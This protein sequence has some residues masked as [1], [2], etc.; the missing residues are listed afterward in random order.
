MDKCIREHGQRFETDWTC[1][2][3]L[4]SCHIFHLEIIYTCSNLTKISIDKKTK[5]YI[6]QSLKRYSSSVFKQ[7][8]RFCS[9]IFLTLA[10]WFF[11]C[12]YVC[13]CILFFSTWTNKHS[14]IVTLLKLIFT[15]CNDKIYLSI[16]SHEY[17]RLKKNPHLF[18]V[19]TSEFILYSL[20]K[21]TTV[22]LNEKVLVDQLLPSKYH[23]GCKLQI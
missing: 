10:W 23:N 2:R 3:H 17:L 18:K 4:N 5:K 15:K 22:I 1:E 8:L 20:N 14:F 12:Y 6:S 7:I 19:M 21:S 16:G 13:T 9:L 11:S